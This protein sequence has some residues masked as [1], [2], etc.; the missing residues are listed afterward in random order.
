MP[1][2]A[3]CEDIRA[4]VRAKEGLGVGVVVEVGAPGEEGVMLLCPR[5]RLFFCY[6][7]G[8]GK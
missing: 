3:L 5:I 1:P 4:G 6:P 7:A 2:A 8:E